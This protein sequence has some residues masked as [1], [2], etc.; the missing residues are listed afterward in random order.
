MAVILWELGRS[1]LDPHLVLV[2][3]TFCFFFFFL[4]HLLYLFKGLSISFCQYSYY[5]FVYIR[6]VYRLEKDKEKGMEWKGS[7]I[8]GP[9]N[10]IVKKRGADD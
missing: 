9:S 7:G 5:M 2:E 10:R 3:T 1:P 4:L 6:G 8:V